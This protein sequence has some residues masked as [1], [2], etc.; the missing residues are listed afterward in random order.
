MTYQIA[1]VLIILLTAVVLFVTERLRVDIVALLV[2]GSLAVTGLVTPT[3]ALSGFSNPAVVTVW[4]IFILSG[5]LAK[6]GV[7]NV[8]GQYILRWSGDG[9]VRLLIV[10][11]VTAGVLS[12]FMNNVGVAALLLP[13][14]MSISRRAKTPP[15]KLLMPLAFA[16]LLGGLTTLIGTPPNILVSDALAEYGLTPFGLF[17]FTP[18]G[19]AVMVTGI[20]FMALI[21]RH[22][23]PVR[24]PA[25]EF[26]GDSRSVLEHATNLGMRVSVVRLPD[27]S[28]LAGKTLAESRFGS[29]L[30]LNVVGIIRNGQSEL[31][32]ESNALLRRGDR[33]LVTGQLDRLAE[34][35]EGEQLVVESDKVTVERLVSNEIELVEIALS[36]HSPFLGQTLAQI[37]FRRTF[38]VTVLAIWVDGISRRTNLQHIPLAAGNTLLVQGSHLQIA[39]LREDPNLLVSEAGVAEV[40][41][42]HERLL[43]VHVPQGSS[44]V[45][46]TLTESRL[47][48]AFG[49]SVVGIVRQEST[50]LAPAPNAQLMAGD[51]LL[52]EGRQED[53]LTLHGLRNLELDSG[54]HI[55]LPDLESEQIGL[56]EVTLSP[57]T[58]LVGKTLRQL[59]FREKYGLNVVAI[60][61]E[62][63]AIQTD[64][65][66]T[67]LRFGDVLLL[68]GQRDKV[69]VLG[70]EPDFLVLSDSV[71]ET[72]R[73]NKAPMALLIMGAVLLSVIVGWLPIYI[74]AVIGAT[75]V[76]LTNCL[77]MDEAYHYIEWKAVFLI[78]GMLPLGIAMQQSGAAEFLAE[79]VVSVVGGLGPRAVVAALFIMAALGAQV[80]PTAAVAVLLAPI[81]MNTAADLGL[82]PY[83]LMMTVA[84]SASASFLSPVAHPA[85]VLTMGPGG[86]RFTDYIRVG[87]PMTLVV[88]VVVL[89]LLPIFWPLAP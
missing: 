59:D 86:Y 16:T 73:L 81:A 52:V 39:A 47:G 21:G 82:S 26:V 64:L 28:A 78:A 20:V 46:K 19:L 35:R 31:M 63:K 68:Y 50:E 43:V 41:G 40:Y 4:A 62:G 48:D 30:G 56:V 75:L 54:E 38:G 67:T 58:T 9:H 44:L 2:L 60:W 34:L 65:R 22:I 69:R 83:A 80:M 49:L 87:L 53:L 32:P 10:I 7:A 11:M 71:Q 29:I 51:T 85:N 36:P 6:T 72:P 1:L 57:Y 42:L 61:R 5:S 79:G 37:D 27:D 70:R 13:V 66:D 23:L 33:L 84:M 8:V 55:N 77:T 18:V 17:D 25:E 45:G 15:S 12:A 89:F 74:A 14:V 24:D 3:Q 76:V 88:L